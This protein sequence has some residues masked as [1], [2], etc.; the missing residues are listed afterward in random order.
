MNNLTNKMTTLSLVKPQW[1]LE[2]EKAH[3]E[4]QIKIKKSELKQEKKV[5]YMQFS[6]NCPEWCNVLCDYDMMDQLSEIEAH[7]HY[8]K[9]FKRDNLEEE[10]RLIYDTIGKEMYTTWR[11]FCELYGFDEHFCCCAGENGYFCICKCNNK[12]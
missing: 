3:K 10:V 6:A 12:L 2:H 1:A 4:Y 9:E 7:A 5:Q 8:V 11:D